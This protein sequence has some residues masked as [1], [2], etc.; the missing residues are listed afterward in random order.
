MEID[1]A[2]VAAKDVIATL[3]ARRE[4]GVALKSALAE[5]RRGLVLDGVLKGGPS[6]KR[7]A[8]LTTE[9]LAADEELVLCFD[10]LAEARLRLQSAETAAA[11]ARETAKAER[12][13]QLAEQHR[14]CGVQLAA[15][16][17]G[18]VADVRAFQESGQSLAAVCPAAPSAELRRVNLKRALE[19]SFAGT[20][21]LGD[22]IPPG[23]RRSVDSVADAESRIC[24]IWARRTLGLEPVPPV[25]QSPKASEAP[26]RAPGRFSVPP[27]SVLNADMI[28]ASESV[29]RKGAR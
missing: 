23:Q 6:L 21:R 29:V 27:G 1:K 15:R 11:E 28:A 12:V 13:L 18:I 10:A 14:Q 19:S 26:Q 25:V 24:E 16:V 3:E 17:Q 2:V 7:L 9:A 22:V 5:E 20:L 8:A 4:Q